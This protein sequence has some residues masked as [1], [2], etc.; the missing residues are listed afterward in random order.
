MTWKGKYSSYLS[1][2][3]CL[4]QCN[5]TRWWWCKNIMRGSTTYVFIY[6]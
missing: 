6:T 3:L 5:T 1:Q 4:L 2:L